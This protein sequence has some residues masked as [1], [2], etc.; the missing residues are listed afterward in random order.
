MKT[1]RYP[2][3]WTYIVTLFLV[4]SVLYV[5]L[6]AFL[7]PKAEAIVDPNKNPVCDVTPGGEQIAKIVD[8][9]DTTYSEKQ[10]IVYKS[11]MSPILNSA[12]RRIC[13]RRS[14]RILSG[15]TST[16]TLRP[17]PKTTRRSW[18]S[19]GISTVSAI[20]V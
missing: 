12:T 18:R 2:Y 14:R 19:T 5:L 3:L 15:V 9:S 4:T 16:N 8:V 6:D 20:K 7:I 17:S 13:A 1:K 11:I 10:T